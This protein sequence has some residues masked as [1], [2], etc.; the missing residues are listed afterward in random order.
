MLITTHVLSGA[1]L[2]RAAGRPLP[3]LL[4]GAASH[5]A[6]DR[7]PHWGRGQGWPPQDLDGDEMRVAVVDG[8][9]GL[10]LIALVL[11]VAPARTRP[12]V[13][14]GI[15]GACAPDLDKPAR[16]YL[17][18]SPWPERFDRLHAELQVGVESPDLLRQ[19]AAVAAAGTG[20]AL[21][22]LARDDSG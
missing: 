15:V 9:V 13:V 2:G 18:G 6:L 21:G 8:L 3:A 10:A 19:D 16:R 20:L 5:L 14:A 1:L 4:L 11:A 17:G 22:A 12:Q 7:L